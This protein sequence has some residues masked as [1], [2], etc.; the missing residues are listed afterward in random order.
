MALILGLDGGASK[1][2]VMVLDTDTDNIFESVSGSSNYISVGIEVAKKNIVKSVLDIIEKIKKSKCT[3]KVFFESSCLGLSGCDLESDINIYNKI[4]FNNELNNFFDPNK[5][6]I[7]NDSKIGLAAGSS[8]KNRIMLICGTG[9]N[10]YGINESGEEARS[11]GWDYI[12]GDEGSAYS[13]SIKA[14][15]AIMRAFDGRG[16]ETSL[17]KNVLKYLGFS[18][19]LELVN[20]VYKNTISKNE[21]AAI[22]SIVCN[23][24]DTGDQISLKI[25]EEE[26]G[27]AILT[28]TTLINK[29]KLK[30]SNFDLVLVGSVFNCKK[31]FKDLFVNQINK[32]FSRVNIKNLVKKPAKGAIKL[33]LENLNKKTNTQGE[34]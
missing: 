5:T 4:I 16:E 34:H 27:E 10:C 2:S 24:A 33:A 20:W 28:V 15:K 18:S 30:N 19:E 25:L 31:Y 26:C 29:L 9:S 17:S 3:K 8:N 21:I 6:I 13:I 1:T 22:A 7:C 32:R 11:N 23:T 14:L 12:L